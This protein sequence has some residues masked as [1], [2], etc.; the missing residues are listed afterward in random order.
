MIVQKLKPIEI[1]PKTASTDGL[2][3]RID[4]VRY[5]EVAKCDSKCIQTEQLRSASNSQQKI[6]ISDEMRRKLSTVFPNSI[7]GENVE[8][9]KIFESY[10]L[11]AEVDHEPEPLNQVSADELHEVE[12]TVYYKTF[13]NPKAVPSQDSS[14]LM[15]ASEEGVQE[16][17]QSV[18]EV[19][20]PSYVIDQVVGSGGGNDDDDDDTDE[21]IEMINLGRLQIGDMMTFHCL[22]LT[23][24]VS[25]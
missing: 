6:Q 5:E 12:E 25:S 14:V 13:V 9:D 10:Q 16:A 15:Y 4:N 20:T 3:H 8:R 17:R 22:D 24:K 18:E 19:R 23:F 11:Y 1:L 21:E 7:E 2:H